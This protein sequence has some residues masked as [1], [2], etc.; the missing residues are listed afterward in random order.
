M[1]GLLKNG[2]KGDAVRALQEK[3]V[4]L[5][6][7]VEV[8]GHFGPVTEKNVRELQRLFGYTVDGIVGEGTTKLAD[9]QL[10]YGFN[11]KAPDAEER[12]LRAQGKAAEADAL[13]AKR[14][15]A[16][17]KGAPVAAKDLGPAKAEAP[18]AKGAPVAKK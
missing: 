2:S 14:E 5:G 6:F 10:G 12:G 16:P 18:P 17:A 9:A 15:A 1:S 7:E 11:A 13:K 3:L 8:D 4:K